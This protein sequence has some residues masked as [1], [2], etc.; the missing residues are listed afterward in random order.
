[1][2]NKSEKSKHEINI[3]KFNAKY[4][5]LQE[6]YSLPEFNS[7]NQSFDLEEIFESNTDFLLRKLRRMIMD[8]ISNFMRFYEILLNPSNAPM[9]FFKIIKKLENYDREKLSGLYD[10]LGNME[11]EAIKL[12]LFYSEEKEAEMIKKS[13][14]LF[15]EQISQDTLEIL[16]KMTSQE[17]ETKKLSKSYVG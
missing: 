6:K 11:L 16:D 10:T 2:E 13:N 3:Q 8:R 17:E 14:K 7:L 15:N 1:M 4:M 9:F 5:L 12:D